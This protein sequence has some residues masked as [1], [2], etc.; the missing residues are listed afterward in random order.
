MALA[1]LR[2][3]E[4]HRAAPQLQQ[5]VAEALVRAAA[6]HA[7]KP[8]VQKLVIKAIYFCMRGNPGS[9]LLLCA[10]RVF[11]LT[12]GLSAE[13]TAMMVC[14]DAV[15]VI[16]NAMQNHLATTPDLL[17]WGCGAIATM[18]RRWSFRKCAVA[19]CACLLLY[20]RLQIQDKMFL[21]M[22]MKSEEQL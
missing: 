10:M 3:S 16:V 1:V 15:P 17:Q 14:L 21:T 7:L 12:I 20:S 2:F 22:S 11:I 5:E 6:T 9:L 13:N 18:M 4:V 19:I 8:K